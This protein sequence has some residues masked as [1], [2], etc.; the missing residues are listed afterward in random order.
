MS[1]T[2]LAVSFQI[3]CQDRILRKEKARLS[4][5][6]MKQIAE[7]RGGSYRPGRDG[8]M[9]HVRDPDK[10]IQQDNLTVLQEFW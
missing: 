8:K 6:E 7:G 10:R 3:F 9:R 2:G 4:V 5:Q 1:D